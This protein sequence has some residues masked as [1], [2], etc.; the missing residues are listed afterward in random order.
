[1]P[2]VTAALPGPHRTLHAAAWPLMAARCSGVLPWA[3]VAAKSEP[4]AASSRTFSALPAL[5][6]RC[7]GVHLPQSTHQPQQSYTA[8]M[9][10]RHK[11][12]TSPCLART[13]WSYQ[14]PTLSLASAPFH[15]AKHLPCR[16][17]H[18]T[19][20]SS[21]AFFTSAPLSSSS[22]STSGLPLQAP[23]T[24]ARHRAVAGAA[25]TLFMEGIIKKHACGAS[26]VMLQENHLCD[27]KCSADT[28]SWLGWLTSPPAATI[29]L[30]M[31][32]ATQL[33]GREDWVDGCEWHLRLHAVHW[34]ERQQTS[35]HAPDA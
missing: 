4:A 34:V 17:S 6:A 8:G 9:H 13:A 3:L 16:A 22:C 21:F 32:C 26:R 7:S 5:E 15:R 33:R 20:P 10:S 35:C 1:M 27:T 19:Y 24:K 25:G 18:A 12:L 29:V 28:K 30:T 14:P 31:S 11:Q 2:D 23:G